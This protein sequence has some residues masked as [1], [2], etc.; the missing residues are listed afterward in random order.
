MIQ[1]TKKIFVT[2]GAGFLGS[3]V[4]KK[5]VKLGHEVSIYDS[6][7]VYTKPDPNVSSFDFITRL[8]DI[9]SDIN[10]IRGDVLNKDFL[11][12]SLNKIKPDIIIHMASMP[13]AALALEHSEE[14]Y[15]SILTSTM[16]I[17]EIIR[18]FD[19]SCRLVYI[20]SS[21]VYGDFTTDPVKESHP[22]SPKDIY[23]AFKL[24]GEHI[25]NGYHRN[26][27]LDTV[28]L[29]PSAVYGPFDSNS[30][31][32]RKF[33]LNAFNNKP[34]TIDGDGS[35][36]MDFSFVEDTATG[37]VKSSLKN[38][39][40]G[41][42]YNI[43]RGEARS[44]RELAQIIQKYFQEVKITFRPK[45]KYI[46]SRGSLDISKAKIDFNFNPNTDLEKGVEKYIAHLQKN[47]F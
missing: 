21:M 4:V 39:I 40:Q 1:G 33:I 24:A 7:V 10:L 34:I 14:A 42:S 41:N 45:P 46:P 23:G 2:G 15:N 47:D 30:R 36:K 38:N 37:I 12:R 28:I 18:D 43:S 3:Q 26:Y 29:R 22:K 20:S 16:N 27:D 32:V 25:V 44:L 13:L 8:N 17:L 19:H 9:F 6:F 5:L 35:L 31:V 11:R